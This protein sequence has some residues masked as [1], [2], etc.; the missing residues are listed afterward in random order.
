MNEC[1]PR[2]TLLKAQLLLKNETIL[3]CVNYLSHLTNLL[4]DPMIRFFF[5]ISTASAG[6]EVKR[7]DIFNLSF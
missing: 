2:K 3:I 6:G 1:N 5:Q 4:T 7:V